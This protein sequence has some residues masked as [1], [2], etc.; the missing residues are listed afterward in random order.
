MARRELERAVKGFLPKGSLG[1]D[2]SVL[3]RCFALYLTGYFSKKVH[4][5]MNIFG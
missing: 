1:H 5:Y 2:R 3:N 4:R